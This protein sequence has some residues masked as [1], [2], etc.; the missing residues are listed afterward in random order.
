MNNFGSAIRGLNP[1]KR[2][3]PPGGS[4]TRHDPGKGSQN[5]L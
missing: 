4:K 2:V 1:P 5:L 3:I